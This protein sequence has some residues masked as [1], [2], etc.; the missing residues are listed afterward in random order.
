MCA[1]RLSD[2]DYDL[3]EQQIAQVPPA[4]RDGGRLLVLDRETG[5]LAEHGAA[6]LGD[7]IPA[8]CLV[9]IN[10]SRVLPARLFARRE[11]GGQVEI[12]LLERQQPGQWRAMLR[13]SKKLASGETLHIRDPDTGGDSG[14]QVHVL[15]SPNAGRAAIEIDDTAIAAHGRMP[16]PP[17][18]RR[19]SERADAE[20]YQ[21]VYARDEGSV[22][23][24]TAGLHLTQQTLQ[25]W[26]DRG[27]EICRVTLH[28]GPGTF[29]PVRSDD[30]TAH[31]ME[32]E[33]YS[34]TSDTAAA[35][36]R[37]KAQGRRVLAVGT[38]SVR[39]LEDRA[40]VAGQARAQLF[41]LPG[42]EFRVVD[43]LL[44]NFHLPKSTLL[45]LVAALAGR[46]RVLAA[47]RH[48]VERGFRFY[49]YGDAMLIL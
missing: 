40:A 14:D 16:L 25:R 6:E 1:L 47:Y 10:D 9:V 20:R 33:R 49:S 37:A 42:H 2:F 46:E 41:I 32:G 29:V 24:P 34:I 39:A 11:S 31:V 43:A 26:R 38:T 36:Q 45:M 8:D 28:V 21:T 27:I 5:A 3:P 22:A 30:P 48:A 44:T 17:Y 18:I 7:L 19:A 13:S 35:I 12:M 15:A 4:R 23:A